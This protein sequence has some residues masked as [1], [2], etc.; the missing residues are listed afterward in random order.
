M[1][2]DAGAMRSVLVFWMKDALR[3]VRDFRDGWIILL[4][5]ET[6]AIVIQ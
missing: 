3:A 4:Y 5:R 1:D 2:V 6:A